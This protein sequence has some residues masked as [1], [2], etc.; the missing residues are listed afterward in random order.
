MFYFSHFV[1]VWS[2][3][4]LLSSCREDQIIL[5]ELLREVQETLRN[6]SRHLHRVWKRAPEW[7]GT[8]VSGGLDSPSDMWHVVITLYS[9]RDGPFLLDQ[10]SLEEW[11]WVLTF[12][13]KQKGL[14]LQASLLTLAGQDCSF[15]ICPQVQGSQ[16]RRCKCIQWFLPI[17]TSGTQVQPCR[18][19]RVDGHLQTPEQTR[20]WK[21]L[22]E[23]K[24]LRFFFFL[25][26]Y[27]I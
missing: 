24:P 9:N 17:S 8:R 15:H 10:S 7:P 25:E 6:Q 19:V 14:D 22:R 16:I 18:S 1:F 23:K 13:W 21:Q 3:A 4:S 27:L 5:D 11:S 20:D 26:V 2:P 12:Q